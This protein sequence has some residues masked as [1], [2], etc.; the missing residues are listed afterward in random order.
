[1]LDNLETSV[2]RSYTE[3]R[4]TTTRYPYPLQKSLRDLS[5]WMLTCSILSLWLPLPLP[6]VEQG[7]SVSGYVSFFKHQGHIPTNISK[8]LQHGSSWC[9]HSHA[10]GLVK[11]TRPRGKYNHHHMESAGKR[12]LWSL[13]T[14]HLSSLGGRTEIFPPSWMGQWPNVRPRHLHPLCFTL[15]KAHIPSK[16]YDPSQTKLQSGRE[17][18]WHVPMGK[19]V[20]NS[21]F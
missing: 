18:C 2:A 10:H 20:G 17:Y 6:E 7:R 3:S 13:L 15:Q 19:T 21:S 14:W 8:A 16:G 4:G 5:T 9:S 1:M 11:V 12:R